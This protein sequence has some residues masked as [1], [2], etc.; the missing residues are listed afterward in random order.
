MRIAVIGGG[1]AGL[2]TAWLLSRRHEVEVFEAADRLGGHANTVDLR[3]EGRRVPVDTGFIVYNEH[4]YPNLTRLYDA[5]GVETVASD[6]SFSV[7]MDGGR[8]EYLGDER[9]LFAQRSNILRPSFWRLLR[10]LLRFYRAAPA[11]L[12]RRDLDRLTLRE[13]LAEGGYSDDFANRHLLP[14]AAAIWSSSLEEILEF[15]ARCFVEFFKNHGL[16]SLG[17]RPQWRS[18]LGGSRR[19]VDVL[20]APFRSGVHLSTP[21]ASLSRTPAGIILTDAGGRQHRFDQVVIAAHADQALA[22]LGQGATPEERRVLG[23][24]RYQENRAVLHRDKALMPRRR[25]AWASWN[26]LAE[27]DGDRTQRIAVSYWMNRLQDLNT[28]QDVFVTLNPIREPAAALTDGSFLY[29]HPQF[30]RAALA[31]QRRL[32][33]IQGLDRVWFCGSYCGYGF[34][35]DGLQAGFAVAEALG[36]PA[37]WA[38]E[39]TPMSPA[40]RAV[41]PAQPAVAAE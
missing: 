32:P 12:Q 6:M 27:G 39:V 11:L 8:F 18:V 36:E 26:Y 10:E 21:I 30:D 14:M 3:L 23:A 17:E 4:N 24:F 16:F 38:A 40:W 33:G 9:G 15:P 5:L 20:S 22:M 34:H 28:K 41:L 19:Y 13:L 31:A 29:H 35:E 7:S 25:R 1:I 37:P 2:G